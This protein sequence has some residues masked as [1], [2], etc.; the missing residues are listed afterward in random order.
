MQTQS[1]IDL[2]E[3]LPSFAYGMLR[4]QNWEV[5]V[6]WTAYL[7][8]LLHHTK[9][10]RDQVVIILSFVSRLEVNDL[11][12]QFKSLASKS[13]SSVLGD[14]GIFRHI[15]MCLHASESCHIRDM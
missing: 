10:R 6:G 2:L 14:G 1:T 12:L 7:Y 13:V 8:A 9:Y 5:E 3:I 4:Q 11:V 15:C